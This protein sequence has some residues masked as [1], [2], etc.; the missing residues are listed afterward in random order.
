MEFYRALLL[1]GMLTSSEPVAGTARSHHHCVDE[2]NRWQ[3]PTVSDEATT[4]QEFVIADFKSFT[5]ACN[6]TDKR[7]CEW[8]IL[9]C[10][11]WRIF[12]CMNGGWLY[13]HMEFDQCRLHS[14]WTVD[15][16]WR[17]RIT[18][19]N[20]E[21]ETYE[22]GPYVTQFTNL[23]RS[24][25]LTRFYPYQYKEDGYTV[26]DHIAVAIEIRFEHV[27]IDHGLQEI[28]DR[29]THLEKLMSDVKNEQE[30]QAAKS[31]ERRTK[32]KQ[33]QQDL[34]AQ[35]EEL[36]S[37]F[38]SRFA[39]RN[40]QMAN[41]EENAVRLQVTNL[42]EEMRDELEEQAAKLTTLQAYERFE[43]LQRQL[44]NVSAF[45]QKLLVAQS[46]PVCISFIIRLIKSAF[47][48][49]ITDKSFK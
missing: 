2:M 16:E 3:Q 35:I 13:L 24:R 36:R 27:K 8:R 31:K 7:Y 19:P 4:K 37:D 47:A 33:R 21:N 23:A 44:E 45:L 14:E 15:V 12:Y 49:T 17:V 25:W 42:V 18:A 30:A 9:G 29:I 20:D 11:K 39:V 32:S 43:R 5:Q 46:K 40:A 41:F 22:N 48:K 1:L 38:N 28:V 34:E 26:E 10:L 6:C